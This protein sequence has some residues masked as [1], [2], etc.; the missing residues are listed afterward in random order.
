MGAV[1]I[2]VD[3]QIEPRTLE[4]WRERIYHESRQEF[5]ARLGVQRMA[6]YYWETGK[7]VPLMRTKRAIAE[8]LGIP[9]EA[10]IWPQARTRRASTPSS[11]ARAGRGE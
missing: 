2:A 7:R 4:Q 8:R 1:D 10:I 9:F 3:T 6:I 11:S 5:A